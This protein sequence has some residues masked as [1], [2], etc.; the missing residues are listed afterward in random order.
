MFS[1]FLEKVIFLLYLF[2][3]TSFTFFLLIS[4]SCFVSVFSVA[5]PFVFFSVRLFQD[6]LQH[7]HSP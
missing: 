7:F 5:I 4:V 6:L 1:I 3:S 2:L